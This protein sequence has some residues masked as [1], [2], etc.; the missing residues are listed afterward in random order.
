MSKRKCCW[1]CEKR[2]VCELVPQIYKSID[3]KW[4]WW[5]KETKKFSKAIYATIATHCKFFKEDP[6]Y[7]KGKT[8]PSCYK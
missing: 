8:L 3:R 5:F 4:G 1:W 2:E 7:K 6:K